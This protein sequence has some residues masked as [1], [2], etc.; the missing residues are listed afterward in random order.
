MLL[1]NLN[2]PT[3]V[4]YI[5][6]MDAFRP[7]YEEKVTHTD[8]TNSLENLSY[9][10]TPQHVDNVDVSGMNLSNPFKLRSSS[11]NAIV[12]YKAIQKVFRARFDEGRSHARLQDFSNSA[13]L[14]PLITAPKAPYENLL[15]KNKD[16]FFELSRYGQSLTTDF[17]DMYQI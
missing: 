11:K 1:N 3:P 14:H 5:H 6:I 10:D 16:A 9:A 17:S 8:P 15:G 2:N 13:V 7:D 12:T 4:S